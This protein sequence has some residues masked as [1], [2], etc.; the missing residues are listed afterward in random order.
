MYIFSIARTLCHY[1]VGQWCRLV[2]IYFTY[3]ASR[4]STTG[5]AVSGFTVTYDDGAVTRS[6]R[7]I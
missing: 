3:V 5:H 1:T 2:Y 6:R 4:G 7:H